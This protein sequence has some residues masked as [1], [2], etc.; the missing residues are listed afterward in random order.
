MLKRCLTMACANI[1][2]L[3]GKLEAIL[4]T[5]DDVY[6][7]S[8]VR[9]SASAIKSVARAALSFGYESSWSSSPPPA[10]ASAVSPGGVGILCRAPLSVR[11]VRVPELERWMNE[12]RLLIVHLLIPG[13]EPILLILIYAYAVSHPSRVDNESFVA[14]VL[15]WAQGMSQPI[16]I[17]GDMNMHREECAALALSHTYGFWHLGP[18]TPSTKGRDSVLSKK[19]PIDHVLGNVALCDLGVKVEVDLS[20]AYSVHYVLAIQVLVPPLEYHVWK[21]PKVT[22]FT[23]HTR[24]DQSLPFPEAQ[25]ITHWSVMA[26]KWLERATGVNIASRT[27]VTTEPFVPSPPKVDHDF[28][29]LDKA[30]RAVANILRWNLPSARAWASVRRKLA[31]L[32]PP[33]LVEC[34]DKSRLSGALEELGV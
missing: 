6:L 17:G 26:T 23:E 33:I 27:R 8:E 13:S 32:Q 20:R 19:G 22:K 29:A 16:L 1:G 5:C 24:A 25:S 31:A 18:L 7:L 3:H 21:W 4:N 30:R 34:N 2:T 14:Q 10:R 15:H 28:C 12:G 9:L 11:K